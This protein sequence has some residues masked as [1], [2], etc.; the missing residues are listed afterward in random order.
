MYAERK[1]FLERIDFMYQNN[2]SYYS[3]QARNGGYAAASLKGRPVAS[4]DEVRASAI[5][6]DGSIFYFPDMGNRRIYTKQI[7]PDGTVSLNLYEL[8]EMPIADSSRIDTNLYITREEFER[9]ID[10]LRNMLIAPAEAPAP[11]PDFKF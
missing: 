9:A 2:Y 6:F 4:L 10:E 8:K 1:L 11:H 5:D 3:Q 7:N